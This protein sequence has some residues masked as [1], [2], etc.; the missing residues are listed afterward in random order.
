M[1]STAPVPPPPSGPP[2]G[3]PFGEGG[4]RAS[5]RRRLVPAA[6]VCA[7]AAV[8]AVTWVAGGFKEA[9]KQPVE[10]PGKA[11]NVGLF[12]VTV[13]DAR[14]GLVKG[15]FDAA[16]KRYLIVRMRVVNNGKETESLG[17]GGLTDGLAA[18]TKAGKWLEP[19]QVEGVAGGAKTDSV[20]PG[21]PVEAS[22]MWQAGPSDA[23]RRF[24]VGLRK[25]EYRTGFTDVS[26]NWLP[27]TE[28]GALAAKMTLPVAA[29]ATPAAP[30]SSPAPFPTRA[31]PPTRAARPP[32]GAARPSSGAAR[33]TARTTRPQRPRPTASP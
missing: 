27:D 25:W 6:V 2:P 28:D 4:D 21:L 8:A 5:A 10:R 30:A 3:E 24:T 18:R 19:D 32:S 13:R 12:T 1:H 14:L 26:Y 7:V 22:A 29:A 33:P 16:P 11:L 31:A 20:Q 15:G 17:N 9:P 23:P